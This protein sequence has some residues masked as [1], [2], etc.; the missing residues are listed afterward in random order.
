VTHFEAT[1]QCS[2]CDRKF[3]DRCGLRRHERIHTGEKQY[4]CHICS[5]AF[6]QST[7]FWVHMENKHGLDKTTARKRLREVQEMKKRLGIKTSISRLDDSPQLAQRVK[8]GTSPVGSWGMGS[9]PDCGVTSPA[10]DGAVVRAGVSMAGSEVKAE[11]RD[12][13]MGS[14]NLL[15]DSVSP[16]VKHE[17]ILGVSPQPLA[18]NEDHGRSSVDTVKMDIVETEPGQSEVAEMSREMVMYRSEPAGV[19][20]EYQAHCPPA[21]VVNLVDMRYGGADRCGVTMGNF[22]EL[23]NVKPLEGD[24]GGTAVVTET[25]QLFYPHPHYSRGADG[26]TTVLVQYAPSPQ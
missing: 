2:T 15:V 19:E 12:G 17:I 25:G 10:S 6:I 11:L 20:F 26:Q 3:K 16:S 4:Q 23:M 13:C 7:P 5:H 14:P 24:D 8:P 9:S 1:L 22:A 18:I 21:Q